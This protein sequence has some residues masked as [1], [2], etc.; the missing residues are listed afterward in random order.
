MCAAS[1][2]FGAVILAGLALIFNLS[3]AM[4]YWQAPGSQAAKMRLISGRQQPGFG[5]LH[6]SK[7]F[8][9]DLRM[10]AQD[11]KHAR[12]PKQYGPR[13]D[14]CRFYNIGEWLWC[15]ALNESAHN[16]IS[17]VWLCHSTEIREAMR[18]K[19]TGRLDSQNFICDRL[20][21]LVGNCPIQDDPQ[22]GGLYRDGIG[23]TAILSPCT[24]VAMVLRL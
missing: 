24:S 2:L 21:V 15:S 23:H 14:Q 6:R 1:I 3:I 22:E 5:G 20:E 9:L 11:L 17:E 7:D 19:C 16:R 12:E 13:R 10:I 18:S 8:H 4:Y